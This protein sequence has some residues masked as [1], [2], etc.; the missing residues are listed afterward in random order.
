MKQKPYNLLLWTGVIF[1]LTSFFVLKNDSTVDIHF[2]DTYFVVPFKHVFWFLA[3]LALLVWTLYLLT[4]KI[5]FSKVLTWTHVTITILTLFLISLT[6]YHGDNIS[7]MKVRRYYDFSSW[8]AINAYDQYTKTIG[9]SL[10]ILIFGQIIY[11]I[12]FAAGLF[13]RRH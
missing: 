3:I 11:I 4:H 6:L 2:H 1:V 7:N 13:K 9:I 8:N 12:N 5:L 10:S